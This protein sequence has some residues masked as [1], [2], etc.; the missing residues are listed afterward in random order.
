MLLCIGSVL[1]PEQ[2]AEARGQIATIRF[3][4][5]KETAGWHARLVKANLQADPTDPRLAR[6]RQR[7]AAAIEGN[8]LFQMAARPRRLGPLL[9]S[10]YEP[11]MGY[12][13]H[14]DDALMGELRSDVSFT[15]FLSEPESYDGGELVME[16]T[17]GEQAYKLPAGGLILYPSTTL[18]RV[19]EVTRGVRL[20]AV[21][22]AQSLVRD[23]AERELLFDLDTARR[24]MF[25]EHGKSPAFDLVAKSF[26]N[27]LRR[28]AET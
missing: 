6:L 1:N 5:G 10:R 15:L 28:W 22:W 7:L 11:G 9:L 23:P 14:V 19:N 16:G 8:E 4:D 20:A 21:G 26:A 24:R 2:L 17:G 13:R 25:R 3:I 18:H 12:G 27:L